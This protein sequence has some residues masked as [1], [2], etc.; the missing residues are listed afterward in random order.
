[1]KVININ[2]GILPIPPNGWGA[3]EKI[4]WDYHL[5]LQKLGVQSEIKYLDEVKYDDSTIVHVHVANLANLCRERG[6]PYI[7]TIHDHHAYVYGKDSRVFRENLEAIENSVFSLTPCKYFI[8]YFGSKKLRY[9]SHAVNTEIFN[10][11]GRQRHKELKLLCVANNGYAY[12]QSV[13]RKGFKIAISAAKRLGLPLT[14]AGPRNNDN[15]FKTLDPELNNY[16]RLTKLYDLDEKWLI[17]Q[18]NEHDAFLHFSELEAGHPNLTLLEAMA[19][20]LPVIGTFEEPVYKGMEVCPRDVDLAV[21]AINNVDK[22]YYDYRE[23]ALQ[24]AEA[25]SYS[26]RVYELVKLYSEYRERIFANQLEVAYKN[27]E[28]VYTEAKNRIKISFDDGAKVEIGGSVNKKYKV[29]FIDGLTNMVNY[30]TE[31]FNTMWASTVTKYYMKWKVEVY[32][33]TDGTETLAQSETIDLKNK[34]VKIVLDSESFGDLLAWIGSVDEFQKKHQCKLSCVVFNKVMREI[35][36]KNYPNIK[37]LAVD[38]YAD[39]FYARY[40][41]GC[42]D[43][44][45]SWTRIPTNARLLN[46]CSIANTILGITDIEYKPKVTFDSNKYKN[47][48]KYVCIATQSTC[49]AKYWNNKGGWS[50]VVKYLKNQGYEVWCIDRYNSFGSKDNMNYMPEGCIDKTGDASFEERMA[51]IAGAKF[52]IGLSSGLSWL[53]WAVNTPVVMISGFTKAYNEFN[54]PYRVINENVCNGCWNDKDIKFDRSNWL[55]CPRNKDF[56]CSKQISTESVLEQVK[57]LI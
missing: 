28:I 43:D 8:P 44:E 24:N 17:S 30:E 15:F 32:D 49:Q 47:K 46:L 57:K 37:F 27:T 39:E 29:K 3:V 19:C 11:N 56:E 38:V 40:R 26:N 6:I 45:N 25:N 54:T 14:I 2:P 31:I 52:F 50:A 13:D 48:K 51:Q 41:I 10:F 34:T 36:E 1:M 7:F 21:A 53:A 5:Q 35:F 33:I 23:A 22:Q 16:P 55:W 9:F 4:I 42:F 18:Y 20:G 12:D